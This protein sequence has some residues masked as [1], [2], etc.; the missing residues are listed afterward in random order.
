MTVNSR[1]LIDGRQHANARAGWRNYRNLRARPLAPNKGRGRLQ[2]AIR[3]C[4]IAFG[5]DVSGSRLY[6]WCDSWQQR[7][8]GRRYRWSVMRI[9]REIAIPVG[10]ATTIGRPLIWR[11]RDG[12]GY[13]MSDD[14]G[15]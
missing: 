11:L 13:G 7:L 3:R 1:E 2:R 10:R 15:K 8:E 4:F 6:D 9:L 12:M 5:P 14:N